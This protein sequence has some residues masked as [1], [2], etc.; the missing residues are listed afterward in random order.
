MQ[1]VCISMLFVVTNVES[2]MP[3]YRSIGT[4][5]KEELGNIC[6]KYNI[7]KG[8]N[9]DQLIVCKSLLNSF[10]QEQ[11]D[12]VKNVLQRVNTVHKEKGSLDQLLQA[13]DE[14]QCLSHIRCAVLFN[15]HYY[16]YSLT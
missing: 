12:A 16:K 7:D 14:T 8:R 3:I 13:L 2:I 1:Q 4:I 5:E 15:L 9:F 10:K 6:M 11:G